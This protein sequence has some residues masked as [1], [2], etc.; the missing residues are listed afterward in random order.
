MA[1][2]DIG[3]IQK[4][5]PEW[6]RAANVPGAALGFVENG[7][8]PVYICEGVQDLHSGM[9]VTAQTVFEAASLSKPVFA[10]AAL[11]L[12]AEGMLDLDAPLPGDLAETLIPD[13]PRLKSLTPRRILSHSSGLP[14]WFQSDRPRAL[15]FQPGERFGYSGEGYYALQKAVEKLSALNLEMLAHQRIFRPLGMKQSSYFRPGD[16]LAAVT[17]GHDGE[18]KPLPVSNLDAP[19]AGTSLHTTIS[20]YCHFLTSFGLLLPSAWQERMLL[21][22]QTRIDDRTAWGLG[23][24]LKLLGND[25]VFWQWGDNKGYKHLAVGSSNQGKAL[26]VL[27]NGERGY[28]VWKKVIQLTFD[29]QDEIFTWLS[30]L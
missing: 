21:A 23:W 19:N 9:P 5:L 15:L 17:G 30:Q 25:W 16:A 4:L 6:M 20:D 29:P 24:G 11:Q 1:P 18:G 8:S 22:P 12:A 10:C 14:N 27:T 26:C 2:F 7:R 13:E 28:E 3:P